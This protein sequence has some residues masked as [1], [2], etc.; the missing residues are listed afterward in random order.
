MGGDMLKIKHNITMNNTIDLSQYSVNPQQGNTTYS[1]ICVCYHIGKS[2]RG[3]HY[4]SH[5]LNSTNN[6]WY[7]YSDETFKPWYKPTVYEK[8]YMLFYKKNTA[9][10]LAGLMGG[11]S[12]NK[13]E[14]YTFF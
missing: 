12:K 11:G 4:I 8:C 5:C 7:E 3:G 9:A 6:K 1:L 14:E 2:P 10:A 13:E